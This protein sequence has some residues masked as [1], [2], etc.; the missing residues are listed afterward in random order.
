[1]LELQDPNGHLKKVAIFFYMKRKPDAIIDFWFNVLSE[2]DWFKKND[3][4]DDMIRRRFRDHVIEAGRGELFYW[5]GSA[6]GRLAEI[7]VLDQFSRNIYR[8]T[9]E[10]FQNDALALILA[11]EMIYLGLHKELTQKQRIFSYMPFMHSESRVIHAEALHLFEELG[12]KET[13]KFEELHKDIIDKFGRFPHRNKIIG[14][15]TTL[16]EQEFLK[17]HSGF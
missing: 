16:R 1:M 4:L 15:T 3:E 17:Q 6:L 9:A 7:I 14:R 2:S 5:R 12:D 13:L 10:S 8:G 11:Q